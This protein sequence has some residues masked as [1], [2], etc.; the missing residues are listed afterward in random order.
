MRGDGLPLA[1]EADQTITW[2]TYVVPTDELLR[3]LDIP[4][5]S[6]SD[7]SLEV[8]NGRLHVG[9]KRIDGESVL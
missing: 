1:R 2:S 5:G 4:A 3:A 8:K 9:V 6:A 7:I